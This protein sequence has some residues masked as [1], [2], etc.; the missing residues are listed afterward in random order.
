MEKTLKG[1]PGGKKKRTAPNL[2][3]ASGKVWAQ[4]RRRATW[5]NKSKGGE[6]VLRA[7]ERLGGG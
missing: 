3:T 5:D 1:F 4:G 6:G 2:G 7:D